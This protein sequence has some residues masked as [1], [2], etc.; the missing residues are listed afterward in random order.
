[1]QRP[2]GG[3]NSQEEHAN[4][5]GPHKA[6]QSSAG[7]KANAISRCQSQQGVEGPIGSSALHPESR[8]ESEGVRTTEGS[9]GVI[10]FQFEFISLD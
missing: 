6:M 5:A 8:G 10:R 3:G 2:C 4:K 7:R 1:M 9:H